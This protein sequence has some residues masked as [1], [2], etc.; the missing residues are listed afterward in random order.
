MLG[1]WGDSPEKD[2]KHILLSLSAL[3]PQNP[4]LKK[5]NKKQ[6]QALA[7]TDQADLPYLACQ[8]CTSPRVQGPQALVF[9]PP[10]FSKE[11]R[12]PPG[13]GPTRAG[14]PR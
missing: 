5:Q 4:N 6:L 12:A 13:Q 2:C 7:T 9:F 10:A 1:F 8:A 14:H 3:S 11:S